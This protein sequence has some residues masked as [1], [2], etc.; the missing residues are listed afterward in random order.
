MENTSLDEIFDW[1]KAN[2]ILTLFLIGLGVVLSDFVLKADKK[3]CPH[4]KSSVD[5]K[6][7]ACPKCTRDI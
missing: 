6:A 3:K 2:P 1:V 4:C 7:T 5:K